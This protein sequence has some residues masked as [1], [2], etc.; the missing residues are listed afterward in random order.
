MPKYLMTFAA[1]V[2]GS[3]VLLAPSFT[4]AGPF[5]DPKERTLT[6]QSAAAAAAARGAPACYVA[7][8]AQ[9]T[10]GVYRAQVWV[11]TANG[12]GFKANDPIPEFTYYY[13][14]PGSSAS[15]YAPG[16][17]A[18]GEVYTETGYTTPNSICTDLQAGTATATVTGK[19]TSTILPGGP[20]HSITYAEKWTYVDANSF[21]VTGHYSAASC[22]ADETIVYIRTGK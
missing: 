17:W 21:I 14:G 2:A 22:V 13:G 4:F 12:C 8:G 11:T 7:S 9:P 15:Y 6:P 5:F 3:L 10:V 16:P 18:P 20:T 1:A 19:A